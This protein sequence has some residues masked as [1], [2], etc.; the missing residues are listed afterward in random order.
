M[1]HVLQIPNHAPVYSISKQPISVR[2]RQV[3]RPVSRVTC[4][5]SP[6]IQGG[7]QRSQYRPEVDGYGA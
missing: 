5:A 3:L 4:K 2:Y 1:L 7:P 6:D